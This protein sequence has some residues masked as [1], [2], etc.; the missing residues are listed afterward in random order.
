MNKTLNSLVAAMLLASSASAFAASSTELTVTG[1]ITPS[2]CEP[3]LS[4]GGNVTYGKIPVKD[5]DPVRPTILGEQ[6]L[7]LTVT[8][9]APTRMALEAKDNREGSDFGNDPM[10]YGLGLI[11]T[12]EKLGDMD[13]FLRL[14]VADGRSARAIISEDGG[15]TWSPS[16]FLS[17]FSITSMADVGTVDPIPAELFTADLVVYPRI[18]PTNQ[19]TLTDEVPIDGSVTLTVIYL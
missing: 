19:L 16:I 2:A 10:K 1:F 14:P 4:N 6:T 18:A 13:V 15:T 5:L 12:T 3:S 7:Q 9:D 17:R 8:C 11:N